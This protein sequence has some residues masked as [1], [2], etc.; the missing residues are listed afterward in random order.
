MWQ[1]V[2]E[3]GMRGQQEKPI[4]PDGPHWT[5]S[6][7]Q[8]AS[9]LETAVD[10]IIVID[11]Q[12]RI[13]TFNRAC[14][15]LFG[16]SAR[17]A[18]GQNVTLIMPESFAI[19]H[20]AKVDRFLQTGERHIIGI[21]REVVG[22]NKDGTEFPVELSVGEAV[23]PEGRQFIGVIRD[24]RQRK[25]VEAR[26]T[27]M[28]AQLVEMARASAMDEIGAAIA[29]ELN[30]PLTAITL[31]L[32][33]VMRKMAEDPASSPKLLAI[34]EKAEQEA[35]RAGETIQRMRRLLEK[36]EPEREWVEVQPF[37]HSCVE[38]IEVGSTVY[39]VTF[40]ADVA[41]NLPTLHIDPIQ[42]RQVL[43]NLL[44]NAREAAAAEG[45]RRHVSLRVR[46]RADAVD[47]VVSDTGAGVPEEIV[48]ELFKAFSGSKYRGLGLGLA[49]SRTIAQTHGGDLFLAEAQKAPGK[50]AT[51][52]LRLPKEEPEDEKHDEADA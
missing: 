27:K 3:S 47:F 46:E 9:V 2:T 52:V 31:Y 10:G 33:A 22:R 35:G 6:H 29:H 42:I 43:L 16:F 21:G 45:G 12:K 14:E 36:R 1:D 32:Q 8:L 25:A 15:V 41:P 51:F 23:T 49:I 11:S 37:V 50:G 34:L 48:P 40:D 7:A 20:D 18:L 39:G 19:V 26:L 4:G 28:Q 5:V 24:L 38:L 44:K 13:L 30:Q 17:E